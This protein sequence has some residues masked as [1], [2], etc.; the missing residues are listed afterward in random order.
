[1]ALREIFLEALDVQPS[2]AC[3]AL[4]DAAQEPDVAIIGE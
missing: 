2:H 1:V 4:V 3:D